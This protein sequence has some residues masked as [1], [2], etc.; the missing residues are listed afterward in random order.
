MDSDTLTIE[1]IGLYVFPELF[2]GSRKVLDVCRVAP[3][4][5]MQSIVSARQARLSQLLYIHVAKVSLRV[6]SH[7]I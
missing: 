6:P 3:I 1:L 7:V 4:L 2:V 5:I